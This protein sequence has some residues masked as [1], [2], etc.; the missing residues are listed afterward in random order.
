M[1]KGAVIMNKYG[2]SLESLLKEH[3]KFLREQSERN[4]QLVDVAEGAGN[5]GLYCGYR[6]AYGLEVMWLEE[7]LKDVGVEG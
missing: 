1:S 4:S 2:E 3:I 6:D 7:I 5:R